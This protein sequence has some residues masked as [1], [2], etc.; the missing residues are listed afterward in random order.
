VLARSSLK[1]DERIISARLNDSTSTEP[2]GGIDMRGIRL[3]ALIMVSGLVLTS[4]TAARAAEE[5]P[6]ATL[7][8]T[9]DSIA[10]G[11]GY[12]WGSGVLHY[13]GK[14]YPFNVN[15]VSVL[16]IGASKA[17]V[18]GKVYNLKKLEDFN[19]SYTAG[20]AGATIGGGGGAAIAQN[21]NG[22]KITLTGTSRG[23]K[24]NLS[25][26]GVKLQLRQ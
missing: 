17:S 9:T 22:V 15:G 23:L 26:D 16:D 25:A 11:V 21:Q 3:A 5:K 7:R 8:F 13:K 20:A 18:V 24:L 6:D 2:T 1:H 19:G 12:S 10:I 14:D 4:G